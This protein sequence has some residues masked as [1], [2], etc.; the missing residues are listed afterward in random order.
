[1]MR[2]MFML[3]WQQYNMDYDVTVAGIWFGSNT[4]MGNTCTST[5]GE[6][7]DLWGLFPME[8]ASEWN[9]APWPDV[10]ELLLNDLWPFLEMLQRELEPRFQ[11]HNY[12]HTWHE[13]RCRQPSTHKDKPFSFKVKGADSEGGNVASSLLVLWRTSR[14]ETQLLTQLLFKRPL[15]S[16]DSFV[17]LWLVEVKCSLSMYSLGA[18]C[19]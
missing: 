9:C 17:V 7:F 13:G 12:I 14:A 3:S 5:P 16:L 10:G 2:H 19:P 1:M 8:S 15:G 18:C 11:L 6:D 4:V